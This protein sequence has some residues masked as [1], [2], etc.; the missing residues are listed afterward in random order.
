MKPLPIILAS[1]ITTVALISYAADQQPELTEPEQK[2]AEQVVSNK[3]DSSL[4]K[5]AAQITIAAKIEAN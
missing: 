5:Y 1:L 3:G 2:S 4:K